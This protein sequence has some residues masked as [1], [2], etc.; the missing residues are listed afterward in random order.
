MNY[1][2]IINAL[3]FFGFVFILS[4]L[5]TGGV[6]KEFAV[7]KVNKAYSG[8]ASLQM[9]GVIFACLLIGINLLADSIDFFRGLV[10]KFGRL[11]FIAV[12]IA[13]IVLNILA[14]IVYPAV[15]GQYKGSEDIED[16]HYPGWSGLLIIGTL[17]DAAS[18]VL[19]FLCG[20]SE[21]G[22]NDEYTE[23]LP[24]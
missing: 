12:N 10:E 7:E 19:T 9:I 24:N 17:L 1:K 22:S 3:F 15:R 11:M 2:G 8:S 23:T 20:K 16:P 5:A 14:I 13:M 6:E 4:S 18:L 21:R